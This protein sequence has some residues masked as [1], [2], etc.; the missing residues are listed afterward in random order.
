MSTF[1]ILLS[2]LLLAPF[3]PKTAPIGPSVASWRLDPE[4]KSLPFDRELLAILH[5]LRK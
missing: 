4:L 3:T 5:T 1:N 2:I